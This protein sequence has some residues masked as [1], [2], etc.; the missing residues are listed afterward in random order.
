[1]ETNKILITT[2]LPE[3]FEKFKV[4][5][6]DKFVLFNFPMIEIKYLPP[7]EHLKQAL[8]QIQDYNWLIFT[9][10]RGI[11]GFFNLVTESGIQAD[12]IKFP[13]IACIGEATED[14]LEKFGYQTSYTNPGNTSQEFGNHLLNGVINSED[15]VLLALGERA[16]NELTEILDKHSSAERINV[17]KTIDVDLVDESLFELIS[18]NEYGLIVFT[19]PS[20]FLNFIKLGNYNP[21]SDQFRIASIGERTSREI[22]N[23]GFKVLLTAKKA[24]MGGLAKEILNYYVGS[25]KS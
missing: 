17:Y 23:S 9:S 6:E 18:R 12:K 25:L 13:K 16:D 7:D 14:E 24:G 21:V 11:R 4:L 19:S 2:F 5:I 1:M 3:Q 20:A 10:K 8:K 15:K 22:E